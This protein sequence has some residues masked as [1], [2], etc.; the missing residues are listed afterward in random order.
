MA[1]ATPADM[2]ARF[3]QDEMRDIAGEPDRRPAALA[4]AGAAIDS[5]LANVYIL[6]LPGGSWP[7]LTSIAADLARAAL[8]DEAPSETVAAARDRAMQVLQNLAD[9]KQLLVDGNGAVAPRRMPV[10]TAEPAG[11]MTRQA[12]ERF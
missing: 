1:Y 11:T 5:Y 2:D 8:Y 10:L 7:L 6:P 4:E 12:L 3:G 9:G